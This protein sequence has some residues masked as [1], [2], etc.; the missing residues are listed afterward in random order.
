[1]S[2]FRLGD[3]A[4]RNK[5]RFR[6]KCEHC[7]GVDRSKMQDNMKKRM[8]KK[9]AERRRKSGIVNA[10]HLP[11]DRVRVQST[12]LH[13]TINVYFITNL[14]LRI[15]LVVARR[16]VLLQYPI[17]VPSSWL[18]QEENNTYWTISSCDSYQG[19]R[20]IVLHRT[21]VLQDYSSTCCTIVL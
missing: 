14:S 5:Y 2:H 13:Y 6:S 7:R 18:I 21:I 16:N 11:R 12:A 4:L 10:S 20:T 17:V 8:E 15:S 3:S 9:K 19:T 1:M